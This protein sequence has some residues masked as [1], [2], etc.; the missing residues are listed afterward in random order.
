MVELFAL[1]SIFDA[2]CI[3]SHPAHDR[4]RTY[5]VLTLPPH[6]LLHRSPYLPCILLATPGGTRFAQGLLERIW[7]EGRVCLYDLVERLTTGH[8]RTS[9]VHTSTR[10]RTRTSATAQ[11]LQIQN[12]KGGAGNEAGSARRG[13]ITSIC[14]YIRGYSRGAKTRIVAYRIRDS[15]R[16]RYFE[17]MMTATREQLVRG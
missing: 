6:S 16:G 14:I 12:K 13:A 17:I 11:A 9:T 4:L 3:V 15:E 10:T 7:R 2:E 1:D 8:K 5:Y